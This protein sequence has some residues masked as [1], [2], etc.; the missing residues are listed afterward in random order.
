MPFPIETERLIL[1]HFQDSDLNAF[2]AYRNDPEVYRYQ[3]WKTPYFLEYATEFIAEMKAAV[4][5]TEGKWFQSALE[6]KQDGAVLGDVAFFPMR[7]KPRQAYV[8]FTL[9]RPYWSQGYASESMR[10]L[11]DYLFGEL[12]FHRLVAEC[13]ADNVNSYRLM[14]RLG[15]R[16]EAQHVES[17]W[18]G[19]RWGSEF[20]YALLEREWLHP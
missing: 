16:R 14:E 20:S 18:L 7:N 8:G 6:R 12:S 9:A 13:D 1:R 11:I 3:G 2:M 15:F 4:P 19:D 17:Y 5:G 10:A